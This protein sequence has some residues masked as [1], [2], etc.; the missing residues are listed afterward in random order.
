MSKF[1]YKVQDIFGNEDVVFMDK[2][3]KKPDL[4]SNYE[5]FL[6]KF[7]DKK[8]TDDCYTPKEVMDII[9]NYVNEKYPL[10]GKKIRPFYPGGT[11]KALFMM[12]NRSL[13]II[14][15]FLLFQKFASTT[16]REI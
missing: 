4:F 3:K 1:S 2:K 8:T 14:R 15:H 6:D 12:A 5:G 7:E 16:F 11:L 10:I 13:L 9:I